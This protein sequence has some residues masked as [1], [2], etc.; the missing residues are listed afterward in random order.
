MFRCSPKYLWRGSLLPA[1]LLPV[2][3]V[4]PSAPFA[5]HRGVRWI[6]L[7]ESRQKGKGEGGGGGRYSLQTAGRAMPPVEPQ[8]AFFGFG[9][10]GLVDD[11]IP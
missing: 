6:S 7:P 11:V 4:M 10:A 1:V 3:P 2:M 8:D 5:P 9:I